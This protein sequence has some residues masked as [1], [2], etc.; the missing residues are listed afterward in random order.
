M[1]F[2]PNIKPRQW[3][4]PSQVQRAVRDY[5]ENT[6]GV[7]TPVLYMPFWEGAGLFQNLMS[8]TKSSSLKYL[9]GVNQ[10]GITVN[11][12]YNTAYNEYPTLTGEALRTGLKSNPKGT[13]FGVCD[14]THLSRSTGQLLQNPSCWSTAV[15][16]IDANQM[17]LRYTHLGKVDYDT[18]YVS[19]PTPGDYSVGYVSY[20]ASTYVRFYHNGS[21]VEQ[22]NVTSVNSGTDDIRILGTFSIGI[23][24]CNIA[25]AFQGTTLTDAQM[26][27]LHATPYAAIQ[28]R[29]FPS[30]FF[31]TTGGAE[32][33]VSPILMM[34]H[35]NGGFLNG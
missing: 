2:N 6:L 24:T 34:D 12:P 28:P 21:F 33:T 13:F 4:P 23:P 9:W 20:G 31:V 30:Y 3:G 32:V 25:I 14:N 19:Q 1:G 16:S 17:K 26:A 7:A 8:G 11:T 29:S 35:F 18:G 15:V 5:Y 10:N 27:L 22:K